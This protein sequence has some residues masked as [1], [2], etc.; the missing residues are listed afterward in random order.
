MKRPVIK[1]VIVVEGKRDKEKVLQAVEAEVVITHGL[2]RDL[3]LL[4]YLKSCERERGVILFCDPDAAGNKIRTW[5]KSK[6]TDVSE[7]F[8]DKKDA[9]KKGK[10]GVEHAS[11]ELV[12]QA[13][14]SAANISAVPTSDLKL[15]DLLDLGINHKA[16]RD[17]AAAVF[18]LGNVNQKQLLCRLKSRG[19]DKAK[20]KEALS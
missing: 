18:S 12:R 3:A 8:L 14:M 6:L 10:V 9:L 16:A 1:E 4:A 5:L 19:I 2:H 13:L 15:S 20:L 11:V 17:R 7:V